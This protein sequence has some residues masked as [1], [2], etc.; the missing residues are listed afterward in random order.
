M[1]LIQRLEKPINGYWDGGAKSTF[2]WSI[3][4]YHKG[5]DAK[6]KF[7]RVGSWSANHYFNVALGKTDKQT[8]ANARRRLS[9]SARKHGMACTFEYANA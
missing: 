6:G 3:E 1:R 4:K 9:A 7:V 5:E 8:L 2:E